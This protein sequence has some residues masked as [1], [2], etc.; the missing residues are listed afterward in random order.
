MRFVRVNSRRIQGAQ[1][2]EDGVQYCIWAPTRAV[3]EVV[4]YSSDGMQ[5]RSVPL[6]REKDGYFTGTD[7]LGRAGD[8]Y[9]LRPD[10][11]WIS[12]SPPPTSNLKEC[13]GRR[14]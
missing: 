13:T 7:P 2:V 1:L 3:V 10:G 14:W 5:L 12:P 11:A 6:L 4:I 8:R 9:K